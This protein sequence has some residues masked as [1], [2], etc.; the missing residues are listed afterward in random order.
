MIQFDEYVS[1]GKPPPSIVFFFNFKLKLS[2]LL[3]W[4]PFILGNEIPWSTNPPLKISKIFSTARP[5][6]THFQCL[7]PNQKTIHP[8]GMS[9]WYLGSMD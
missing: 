2:N 9:C 3:Q 1:S 7:R 5:N 6:P 8:T 4:N